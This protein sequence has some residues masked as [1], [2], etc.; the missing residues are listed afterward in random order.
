MID[1]VSDSSGKPAA[2]ANEFLNAFFA[3]LFFTITRN[4]FLP[5][6]MNDNIL[7]TI[8][9][10]FGLIAIRSVR[11]FKGNVP[12]FCYETEDESFKRV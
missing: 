2:D 11:I 12:D 6:T 7:E 5:D 9:F 4:D 1:H 8:F 10:K 3:V